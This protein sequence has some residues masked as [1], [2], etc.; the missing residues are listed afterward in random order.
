[1]QAPPRRTSVPAASPAPAPEKKSPMMLIVILVA[2]L[3]LGVGGYVGYT[4]FF[5]E[6]KATAYVEINVTPW[7]K[8]KNITTVDGKRTVTLPSETETPLRVV[9]A[10]G[11]YKVTIAGPDG[12][13]KSEMV[14]VTDDS[15]GTCCN[16]V[17]QQIDVEKV[18]NAH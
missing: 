16:I 11:D 7:G 10:P 14:K 6:P 12:S 15:P 1:V 17:F 2:A 13:E 3:L 5:G 8:V 18:I 9:L 4:K